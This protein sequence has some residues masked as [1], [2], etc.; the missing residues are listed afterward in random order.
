MRP[1]FFPW[2]MWVFYNLEQL[3]RKNPISGGHSGV[4]FQEIWA[5]DVDDSDVVIH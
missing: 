1:V 2:L 4:T 3:H 5:F